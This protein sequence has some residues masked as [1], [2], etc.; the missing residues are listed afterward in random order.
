MKK[1][2]TEILFEEVQQFAK[3]SVR[4]FLKILT[5]IFFIVVIASLILHKG[6]MTDFAWVLM[7]VLSISL[8][9]NF[10]LGSKLILQ[11]R[12]DGIYVRFPPWQPFFS[13]Y[14]WSDLSEVY[15]REYEAMKE[16][17]GW[18]L[19]MQPGRIGY[20]VAGNT[21]IEIILTNG[22]KILITTQQSDEINELLRQLQ[23]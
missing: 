4:E 20:I 22:K 11:I 19:R 15:V 12:T 13:K 16:F 10:I 18:G 8:L 21:G 5:G 9:F 14:Y 23:K 17:F 6:E 7:V 1:A 3:R 2:E